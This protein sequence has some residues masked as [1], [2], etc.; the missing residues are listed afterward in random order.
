MS[1]NSG[2]VFAFVLN[3]IGGGRALDFEGA[4][5]SP[6]GQ[7]DMLRILILSG[8]GPSSPRKSSITVWPSK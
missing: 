7:R 4:K 3:G 5:K 1:E 2:F 8:I 6:T